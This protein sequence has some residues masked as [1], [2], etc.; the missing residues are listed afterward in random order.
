MDQK[1]NKNPIKRTPQVKFYSGYK[2]REA[3]RS[4]ILGDKEIAVKKIKERKRVLDPKTNQIVDQFVCQIQD[5][6][7][8]IKVPESKQSNKVEVYK[9]TKKE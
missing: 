2:K 6:T 8:I 3:P 1:Q 9:K 5:Q 7:Y 4:I